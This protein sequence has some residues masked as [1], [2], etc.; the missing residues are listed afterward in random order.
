MPP[1]IPADFQSVESAARDWSMTCGG[2]GIEA[3]GSEILELDD[4]TCSLASR[5]SFIIADCAGTWTGYQ[6]QVLSLSSTN[7]PSVH[8]S[9]YHTTSLLLIK[10]LCNESLRNRMNS[11]EIWPSLALIGSKALISVPSITGKF[12]LHMRRGTRRF[13]LVSPA[14]MSPDSEKVYSTQVPSEAHSEAVLLKATLAR[15]TS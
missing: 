1:E 4:F 7:T 3:Y 6:L 5:A 2:T 10:P 8:S 15:S 12:D 13:D 11:S 9:R 14:Q